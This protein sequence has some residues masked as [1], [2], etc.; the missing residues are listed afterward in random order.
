V[1]YANVDCLKL[2]RN[3]KNNLNAAL[4]EHVIFMVAYNKVIYTPWTPIGKILIEAI[5]TKEKPEILMLTT[6]EGAIKDA[7]S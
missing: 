7:Y 2:V 1:Y 5:R 6:K 4:A 3:L